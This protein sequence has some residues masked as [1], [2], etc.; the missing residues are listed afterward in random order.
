[1]GKDREGTF[2]PKKGK[3]S[4]GGKPESTTTGL[5]DIN[6]EDIEGYMEVA[7]K[8]TVGEEEPAPN[9]HVRHKN[10]NVDKGEEKKN[11]KRDNTNDTNE[12]YKSKNETF[13]N[14]R[15][16]TVPEELPTFLSKEQLTELASF[17]SDVCVTVY[18]T[19]HTAGVE[20]NEQKDIIAFKNLLQ[21]ITSNLRQK[22]FDMGRIENLLKPG[23]DL[24]RND[25]F[26]FKL[27]QGLAIFIADNHFKYM[28]LPLV[29][30]DGVLIN[31]SFYV[32]PLL[33]IL[34]TKEYFYVLVLS[35]KQSKLYKADAFGMTYIPVPELPNGVDDVVRFEEKEDQ[36]LFRTDTA[37]AGQGA[38]FHGIGAGKPDE[39][40]HLSIYFDE[41]DET[42]WKEILKT[43]TVPLV[44]AGVEYLIPLY[45]GVAEYK[46][47]WEQAITGSHEHDDINTLYQQARQLVEPYFQQKVNKALEAYGNQSATEKTSSIPA[48]VIPAAHYGRISH[49]FV[50]KDQHIWGSFDEMENK[51]TLHETQQ[52]NDE[53][54]IDKTVMKTLLT[55]GEVHL[56][57]KE[58]MPGQS[59]LAAIMRYEI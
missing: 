18:L 25:E 4:G 10:R 22:G 20:K 8:Y 15:T 27:S 36:K 41:V 55:G 5:K 50:Q 56:L 19:T 44:L 48:D 33:P 6:T 43:E 39:K 14:D 58:K 49:L 46:H 47:I 17:N 13:V 29:P 9:L 24:L 35:K 38:N 3:P 42:L 52:D 57:E 11:D 21:Q 53:D 23:Y 40:K 59:Q 30:N 7:D 31:S 54:L 26:W 12:S 34:T 1:M 32:T 16:S 37:G 45:K 2:H 28:K 51:L